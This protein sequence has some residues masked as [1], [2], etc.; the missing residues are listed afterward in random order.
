MTSA[1]VAL[2]STDV[3]RPV[4]Y[5]RAKLANLVYCSKKARRDAPWDRCGAWRR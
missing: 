5:V 4:N 3:L 2:G 1:R